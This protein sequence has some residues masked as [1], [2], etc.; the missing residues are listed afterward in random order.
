M[1]IKHLTLHITMMTLLLLLPFGMSAQA[2]KKE[3]TRGMTT[4]EVLSILGKPDNKSFDS[5]GER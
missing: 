5:N 4:E 2:R 1:Q 3:V